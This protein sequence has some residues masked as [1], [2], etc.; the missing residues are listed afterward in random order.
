MTKGWLIHWVLNVFV[1]GLICF[2]AIKCTKKV[3]TTTA[4]IEVL[5]YKINENHKEFIKL[6]QKSHEVDSIIL[7]NIDSLNVN[8][9]PLSSGGIDLY[10]SGSNE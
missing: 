7:R 5:R 4:E 9:I 8:H 3:E 2:C 10:W 6:K 1:S